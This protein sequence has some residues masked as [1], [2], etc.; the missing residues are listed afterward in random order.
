MSS[1]GRGS[2]LALRYGGRA[3]A[4]APGN[5]GG[6]VGSKAVGK[7]D[8]TTFLNPIRGLFCAPRAITWKAQSGLQT[9]LLRLNSPNISKLPAQYGVCRQMKWRICKDLPMVA[10]QCPSI[11]AAVTVRAS[12]Y[13]YCRLAPRDDNY[14][15][16]HPSTSGDFSF[17]RSEFRTAET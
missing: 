1:R 9:A 10:S 4:F 15:G 7:P 6:R 8:K 11:G 12:C 16:A 5:D 3:P 17:R 13:P 14:R 2:R